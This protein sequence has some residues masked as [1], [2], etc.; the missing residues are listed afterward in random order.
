MGAPAAAAAADDD[1]HA[2]SLMLPLRCPCPPPRQ[3]LPHCP[4][5][6]AAAAPKWVGAR[7]WGE[8]RGAQ[9]GG[10]Q[11]AGGRG[12]RCAPGPAPALAAAWWP[13]GCRPEPAR[14]GPHRAAG[15]SSPP[16]GRC[17]Y[18]KCQGAARIC[19]HS[20]QQGSPCVQ[21]REAE[22][23]WQTK[24]ESEGVRVCGIQRERDGGRGATHLIFYAQLVA[25]NI[26]DL[27]LA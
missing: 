6:A 5:P 13:L 14:R 22:G 16:S 3:R 10:C 21:R 25:A 23:D 15:R 2:C 11:G 27:Q 26:Q 20:D 19:R 18:R 7:A 8:Q 1:F 4:A 9:A 17:G 12:K 24:G